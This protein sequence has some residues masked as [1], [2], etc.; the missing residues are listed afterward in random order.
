M[1]KKDGRRIDQAL[2]PRILP[3]TGCRLAP[4]CEACTLP[5]CY[6]EMSSREVVYVLNYSKFSAY[7]AQGIPV[8]E[9]QK[10]MGLS[11]STIR[12]YLN[13]QLPNTSKGK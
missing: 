9:I 12:R 7:Q 8:K 1:S 2:G 6:H 10:L 11:D 3:D 4:S 13:S 5:K